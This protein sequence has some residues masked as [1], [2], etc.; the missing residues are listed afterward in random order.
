MTEP[1]WIEVWPEA[2]GFWRW[3]YRNPPEGIDLLANESHS[4]RAEA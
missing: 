1:E 4:N 2:D 3:R